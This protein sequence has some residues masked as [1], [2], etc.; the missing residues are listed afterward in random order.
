MID[1]TVFT[2]STSQ[3]CSQENAGYGTDW[4]YRVFSQIW[5]EPDVPESGRQYLTIRKVWPPLKCKLPDYP[6]PGDISMVGDKEEFP[7]GFSNEELLITLKRMR[8]A[9]D[10]PV[11]C[12]AEWQRQVAHPYPL[13]NGANCDGA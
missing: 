5:T 10:K 13:S 3:L 7:S 4:E 11:L 1:L 9:L 6:V 8:S 2:G 12:L